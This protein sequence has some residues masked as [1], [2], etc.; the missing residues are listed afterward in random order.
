MVSLV[1]VSGWWP[2]WGCDAP[3]SVFSE[4]VALGLQLHLLTAAPS[5]PKGLLPPQGAA[6]MGNI[7]DLRVHSDGLWL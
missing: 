4:A 2:P 3:H 6:R 1:A 7:T 5:D